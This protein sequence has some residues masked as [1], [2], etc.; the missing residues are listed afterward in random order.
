MGQHGFFSRFAGL[1]MIALC[2]VVAMAVQSLSGQGDKGPSSKANVYVYPKKLTAKD[3]LSFGPG[4]DQ[5]ETSWWLVLNGERLFCDGKDF[6][7]DFP[8]NLSGK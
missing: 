8:V 3:K 6:K 4:K 5:K 7:V 1:A 2:C